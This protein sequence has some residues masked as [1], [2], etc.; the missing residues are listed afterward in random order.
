MA[1]SLGERNDILEGR[2]VCV[3]LT[4]SGEVDIAATESVDPAAVSPITRAPFQVDPAAVP[5]LR[6]RGSRAGGEVVR[7]RRVVDGRGGFAAGGS[8][9]ADESGREIRGGEGPECR[10]Q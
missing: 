7:R 10:A 4:K 9:I 1:L 8:I 3:G 2:P 5:R 6:C